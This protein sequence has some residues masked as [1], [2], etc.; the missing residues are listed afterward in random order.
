VLEET[1]DAVDRDG[2]FTDARGEVRRTAYVEGRSACY[3]HGR[4]NAGA[5][6]ERARELR[7]ETRR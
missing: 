1:A 3:G 5:A 2:T 6:V 4:V 7:A